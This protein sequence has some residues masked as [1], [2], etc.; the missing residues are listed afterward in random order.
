MAK[1]S[2][3]W[4]N[5]LPNHIE[6]HR[7]KTLIEKFDPLHSSQPKNLCHPGLIKGLTISPQIRHFRNMLVC[8]NRELESLVDLP[9]FHVTLYTLDLSADQHVAP[10]CG[11]GTVLPPLPPPWWYDGRRPLCL[12]YSIWQPHRNIY[13]RYAPDMHQICPRYAQDMPMLCP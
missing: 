13:P 10:P 12:P 8:T 7:K 2:C 4:N 6:K 3:F 1:Y 9:S 11:G 5:C